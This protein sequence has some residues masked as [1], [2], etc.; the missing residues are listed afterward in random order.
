MATKT[1]LPLLFGTAFLTACASGPDLT[2]IERIGFI[3]AFGAEA[4]APL[5]TLLLLV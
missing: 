5:P 4:A 3:R 2:R 1:L